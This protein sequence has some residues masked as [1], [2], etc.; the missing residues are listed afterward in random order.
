[1]FVII[2]ITTAINLD[3]NR[4]IFI[5]IIYFSL[6]HLKAKNGQELKFRVESYICS[7]QLV[8]FEHLVERNGGAK[9]GVDDV[10]VVVQ[11]LV[12]H[13]SKD[14][15]LGSATVVQFNGC[16]TALL[17]S[18]PKIHKCVHERV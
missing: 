10:W 14:T 5:N 6:S 12:N 1:M 7:S 3:I 8:S 9:K 2:N 17:L 13:Q 16:L 11:L 18:A 15:H 4:L